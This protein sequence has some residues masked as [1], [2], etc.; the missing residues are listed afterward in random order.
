M[1]S[2]ASIVCNPADLFKRSAPC[3][4]VSSKPGFANVEPTPDNVEP[5]FKSVKPSS[6]FQTVGLGFVL[7]LLGSMVLLP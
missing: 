7:L 3:K 1:W 5:S 2:P 6:C 4:S